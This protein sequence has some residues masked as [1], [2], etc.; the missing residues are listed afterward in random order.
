MSLFDGKDGKNDNLK[1]A[2]QIHI[3]FAYSKH[4]R[5]LSLWLWKA[6]R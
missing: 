5:R 4:A 1:E 2:I 6:K 3:I